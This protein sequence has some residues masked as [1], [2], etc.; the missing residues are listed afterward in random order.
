MDDYPKQLAPEF[1]E[2]GGV[3]TPF[4]EWWQ[5]TKSSFPHVP[6]EVARDW[7]H[8][9]WSHSP[10]GWLPSASYRFRL[11][12]WPSERLKEIRTIWNSYKDDPTEP[13]DHGRHLVQHVMKPYGYKPA[14]VMVETGTFPVPPIM[15]DNCDGHLAETSGA[16]FDYPAG[17]ILVEGH[18]RFNL[19]AYLESD[20]R[21]NKTVPF[22]LMERIAKP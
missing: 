21:L 15:L 22:W 12:D 5:V 19:A 1:D 13:I 20:S 6:D 17:W 2:G 4:Q 9:H 7:L 3:A 16:R 14:E 11:V 8:R 18:R 10:F